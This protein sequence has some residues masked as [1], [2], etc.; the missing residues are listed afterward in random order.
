MTRMY[1]R[2][3]RASGLCMRGARAWAERHNINYTEFLKHGIECDVLE[4]TG[5]HFALTVCK[6]A[7]EEEAQKNEVSN[8]QE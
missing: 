5:D 7:R 1:V 6:L 8:G 3:I 2:H 4:A